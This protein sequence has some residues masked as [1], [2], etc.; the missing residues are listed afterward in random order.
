MTKS[1]P[2]ALRLEWPT[3]NS[4]RMVI[5]VLCILLPCL[6]NQQSLGSFPCEAQVGYLCYV[7]GILASRASVATKRSTSCSLL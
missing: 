2:S 3:P 4:M 7:A 6:R 5:P 1:Q